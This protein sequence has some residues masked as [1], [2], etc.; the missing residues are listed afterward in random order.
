MS[1]S[2]ELTDPDLF[3]AGAIGQ[4]GHRVFYLQ[5]RQDGAVVTFKCEKQQVAALADYLEGLLS[6]L[7]DLPDPTDAA[8]SSA[9]SPSMD[10]I[11]PAIDE[12]VV[13]AL[14]VAYN[15]VADR[16]II[17]AEELLIAP[18]DISEAEA[19][20]LAANAGRAKFSISRAQVAR[21]VPHAHALVTAGRP[22]CFLCG[23]P[24]DPEGHVCPRNN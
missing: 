15:N 13:G 11:E 2:F 23:R 6:D 20:E 17:E 24:L 19:E 7:P 5:A 18:D 9:E 8:L 22:P 1:G 4:P 12:W 3:T 21:F 10:L 14:G 16:F